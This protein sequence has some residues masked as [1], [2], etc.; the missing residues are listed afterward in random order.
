MSNLHI[1]SF[2]YLL[3]AGWLKGTAQCAQFSNMT[4][5]LRF[6]KSF[7]LFANKDI[8][9]LSKALLKYTETQEERMPAY[10]EL[11]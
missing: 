7:N 11:K 6:A 1:L 2:N 9:T 8:G 10:R 3:L 5:I 4:N